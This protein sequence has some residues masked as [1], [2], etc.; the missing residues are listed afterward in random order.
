MARLS[1]VSLRFAFAFIAVVLISG[2]ELDSHL[3]PTKGS[4]GIA[5][6]LAA[7]APTLDPKDDL[8]AR[9]RLS[10]SYGK[11]PISFEVNQG[12]TAGVVQYL[13]RG[14]GYTLFLAPGEMVLSLHASPPA[15]SN[16]HGTAFRTETMPPATAGA[17]KPDFLRMQLIGSNEQAQAL[18]VDPLPGKSNYFIGND[19]AKWHTR[20]PTYARVRYQ[21]VYPGIDL[22][23]YGNQ[24]GKLEHDFVVAPGADPMQISFGIGD[25]HGMAVEHEGG[26][27][28]RTEVGDLDLMRPVAYQTIDGQKKIIPAGYEIRSDNRIRFRLGKYDP[29]A[30]LVVDPVLVY[31][32]TFG[33]SGIAAFDKPDVGTGFTMDAAGN[34][35]VTGNTASPDFPLVNPY[36]SSPTGGTVGFVSKINNAGTTLLYSTYFGGT[37]ASCTYEN[38]LSVAVDSSGR[39]YLSGETSGGLPVKNAYQPVSGGGADAFVSVLSPDGGSLEWSTYLGGSGSDVANSM[40]LDPSGNVYVSGITD[41]G[42]PTLHSVHPQGPGVWVAKFSQSGALQYS[43]LI[44]TTVSNGN[45]VAV[46]S[47]GAAYVAGLSSIAATPGAFRTTCPLGLCA[48]VAK[49]NPSGDSLAYA[50]YFGVNNPLITGLSVAVDSD[51]NAYIAGTAGGGMPVWSSGLQ[52]TVGSSGANGFVAKLNATGSNLIWSTYLGGNSVTY[53]TA[54]ALDQHRTVYVAGTSCGPGFPLK[55]PIQTFVSGGCQYFVTTLSGSLSSIPYYSTY[56]GT[57]A[58]LTPLSMPRGI[59]VDRS[60]NVYVGGTNNGKIQPTSGAPLMGTSTIFVSKLVIMD[61]LT[62]AMSASPDPVTQGGYLT[63]TIA[64]TSKGPDFGYNVR[65]SD[66]LPSGTTFASFDAGGGT[67]TAPPVGSTGTLNCVLP[68]LN[69]GATWNV[70]LRVHVNAA[71]GAILSNTAATLSNMQ[72]FVIGNNSA[73]ITTQVN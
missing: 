38:C 26:L 33:G 43:S 17:G 41:G 29:H 73:A 19:P 28:L 56:L 69:K 9:A 14:A 50:T 65:V 16:L 54:L 51:H 4:F 62:L 27:R 48:W 66:T 67:C 57:A 46:D 10:S 42:F 30:A 6:A 39:I 24:E 34:L 3:K 7:T 20:I 15:A 55:A 44:S 18:G 8:A 11:L 60:L 70:K 53:I 71:S 47:T 25:G 31:T 1:H 2:L 52:R 12:Q 40:A 21:D 23:Y 32:A 45:S 36:P 37:G 22:V 64:V 35:Y 13:A 49:L 61:D 63:Y 58:P 59:V 72:D 5:R 68:Q